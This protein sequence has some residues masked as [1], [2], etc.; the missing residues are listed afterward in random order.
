[1]ILIDLSIYLIYFLSPDII[2]ICFP[3]KAKYWSYTKA[4]SW[5]RKFIPPQIHAFIE[6]NSV[7]PEIVAVIHMNKWTTNF[8]TYILFG[9]SSNLFGLITDNH[10]TNKHSCEEF[11]QEGKYHILFY[12]RKS[13]SSL[14]LKKFLLF[15]FFDCLK[16]VYLKINT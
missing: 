2:I 10:T 11:F 9:R 13:V 15:S 8:S 4:D 1:M 5:Y 12:K 7:F 6:I 14:K 16:L 3:N